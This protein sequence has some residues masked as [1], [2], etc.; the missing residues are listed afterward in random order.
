MTDA[1]IGLCHKALR[2]GKVFT[3]IDGTTD[4]ADLHAAGTI[5]AMA[6]MRP[7]TE[8]DVERAMRARAILDERLSGAKKKEKKGLSSGPIRDTDVPLRTSPRAAVAA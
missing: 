6:L 8:E 5:A 1:A 2:K 3:R 7:K 4:D